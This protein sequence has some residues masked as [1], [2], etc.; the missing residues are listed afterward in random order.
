M[1]V[2]LGLIVAF[3]LVA[4]YSNPKRRTCRWREYRQS[5]GTTWH[6]IQC[7]AQVTAPPGRP[8]QDCFRKAG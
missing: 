7:G 8:P 1:L 5:S 6:C 2:A 3:V 4:V